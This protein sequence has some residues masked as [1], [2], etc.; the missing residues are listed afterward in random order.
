V[1]TCIK[2]AYEVRITSIVWV[3]CK[4]CVAYKISKQVHLPAPKLKVSAHKQKS[5]FNAK[6]RTEK[7]NFGIVKKDLKNKR[8]RK[9]ECF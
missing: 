9:K 4:C 6:A 3:K 5:L 7:M 2:I 1:I 8:P